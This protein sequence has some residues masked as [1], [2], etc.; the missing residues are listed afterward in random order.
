MPNYNAERNLE[1]YIITKF[2]KKES[3]L[4]EIE[5]S[6][7]FFSHCH[8]LPDFA[9]ISFILD[10]LNK[11]I[12]TWCIKYRIKLIDRIKKIFRRK[13]SNR[14]NKIITKK[15]SRKVS[16]LVLSFIRDKL[17]KN[18]SE[19]QIFKVIE[20]KQPP[21]EFEDLFLYEVVDFNLYN[22][23][24]KKAEYEQTYNYDI[25]KEDKKKKCKNCG[26][27]MNIN[28]KVCPRCKTKSD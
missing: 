14:I 3:E 18:F 12:W 26:W 8:E 24:Y 27:V 11:I 13:K 10:N 19:Y 4:E 1:M 9:G 6:R 17:Q 28:R 25:K 5:V 16:R 21:K 2:D 15:S 20:G 23:H 7:N 22:R